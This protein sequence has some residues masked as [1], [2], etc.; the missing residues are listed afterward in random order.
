MSSDEEASASDPYGV[1]AREHRL[2]ERVLDALGL[3]CSLALRDKRLDAP[4]ATL[5]VRFLREFADRTH[6]LKEEHI[7]F[8]AIEAKGYFPGCGLA[9]EHEE[10]RQRI[11]RMEAAVDGAAK[12]DQEATRVFVHTARAYIQALREHI[13][14]EDDCLADVVMKSLSREDRAAV[15]RQFDDLERREI[16]ESLLAQFTAI[17]E[18]LE[19]RHRREPLA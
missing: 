16:G 6:H 8:P 15:A 1:L 18:D 9:R 4:A 10:A 11:R 19:N 17:A 7:L 3:V 12:G 5:A 2:I 14:K 13:A